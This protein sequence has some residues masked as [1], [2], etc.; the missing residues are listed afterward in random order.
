MSI[1]CR[2]AN[3][4]KWFNMGLCKY[5][6]ALIILSVSGISG[7]IV[8]SHFLAE[9]YISL[10]SAPYSKPFF[11]KKGISDFQHSKNLNFG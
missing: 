8:I 5:I 4:L 3:L 9:K 7:F 6:T 2:D 11:V 1:E 10:H